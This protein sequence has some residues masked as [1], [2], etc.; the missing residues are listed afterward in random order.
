[1]KTILLFKKYIHIF[2]FKKAKTEKNDLML[3]K[4]YYMKSLINDS[5]DAIKYLDSV[6][7]SS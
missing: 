7:V 2:F 5:Y 1:M 3:A 4:G 6:I